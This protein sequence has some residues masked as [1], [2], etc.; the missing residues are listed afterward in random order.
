MTTRVKKRLADD[1]GRFDKEE[2]LGHISNNALGRPLLPDGAARTVGEAV[3]NALKKEKRLTAEAKAKWSV[4]IS[5]ARAAARQDPD[6]LV[7]IVDHKE[8]RDAELAAILN[9][10]YDFKLPNATVGAKRKHADAPNPIHALRRAEAA[11][12]ES[13]RELQKARDELDRLGPHGPFMPAWPEDSDDEDGEAAAVR[14]FVLCA[15]VRRATT[16]T[17]S[18]PMGEHARRTPKEDPSQ[19]EACCLG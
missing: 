2:L 10:E 1:Q 12:R 3:N 4:T 5:E 18:V 16:P 9:Q 7:A 8:A 19:G 14:A 15:S 6:Q 13:A 11:A 17:H